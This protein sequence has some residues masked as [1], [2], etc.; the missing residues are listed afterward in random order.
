MFTTFCVTLPVFGSCPLRAQYCSPN[1]SIVS[2]FLSPQL[3]LPPYRKSSFLL[4]KKKKKSKS[5]NLSWLFLKY[6]LWIMLLQLSHFFPPLYSPLPCIPLPPA[7]PHLSSC[8]WV[9][10]TSLLASPSPILFLTSPCLF[11]TYNLCFLFPVSFPLT[12]PLP[13]PLLADKPPCDLHFCDSV[14][15]LVACL[16]C[17]C[18]CFRCGCWWLWVCCHF[19][20]HIFIIFF[21]LD[22]SL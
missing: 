18:F 3:S 9:I 5:L 17:F 16:V 6:M 22:K 20:V 7:F 13:L 19:I 4:L 12:S 8:P 15:V 2:P 10:H 14:S 11:W 21:F 1:I